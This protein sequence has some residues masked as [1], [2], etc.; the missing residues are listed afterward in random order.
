[1]NWKKMKILLETLRCFIFTLLH[2]CYTF[3]INQ[4][5]LFRYFY[6]K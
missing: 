1:M 3:F 4:T 5:P 2:K 6:G